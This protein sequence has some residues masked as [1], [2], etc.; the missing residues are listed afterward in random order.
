MSA[1]GTRSRHHD[2]GSGETIRYLR[3]DPQSRVLGPGRRAVLMVQ[4]CELRCSGCIV[5]ESHPRD[6]AMLASVAEIYGWIRTGPPIDGITFTGG[7]PMLQA[8]A[9]VNLVD[10]LRSWR[11]ELSVMS[12]S[13]Y[14]LERLRARG[15][16]TQRELLDRLDLLVDGPFVASRHE[17]LLWRAST[18][19]RVLR[20][21][22]RHSGEIWAD[23]SAGVEVEIDGELGV[24]ITGVPPIPRFLE[25]MREM[26]EAAASRPETSAVNNPKADDR[27]EPE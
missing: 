19:Q 3:L 2:A 8:R 16:D 14:R 24:L 15:S 17:N 18:N 26:A 21:S 12:F 13:G 11:P 7:E 25:R 20:L 9:L 4:G 1:R 22:D 6:G 23:R 5:P 27:K 10:R